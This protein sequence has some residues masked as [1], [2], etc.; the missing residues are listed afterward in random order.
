MMLYEKKEDILKVTNVSLSYENSL[1]LR[2][3]NIEIDNIVRPGVKQG[4]VISFL[5]P[6]GIGKSQLSKLIAGLNS[7]TTGEVRVGQDLGLVEAGDVGYVTQNY[8]LR[9]NRTVIGNLKLAAQKLNKIE[10][11]EKIEY[12]INILGLRGLEKFYPAQLSG[13]QRQR[14]AIAQQLLCSLHF[15]I[16]DEPFTGLDPVMREKTCDI[17]L[18]LSLQDELNTIIIISHEL[19]TVLKLSDTVWLMGRD[20]D[21]KGNII[22]GAYI[23]ETLDLAKM[24]L[25]WQPDIVKNPKFLDLVNDIENKFQYL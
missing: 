5:G 2:D 8:F 15:L 23:K 25:C 7:P 24:D 14:V 10:A 9:E 12:Y 22:P 6:S 20:R 13:G 11:K 21:E 3:I 16:M 1:I 18:N 17:I 4:Q 19:R